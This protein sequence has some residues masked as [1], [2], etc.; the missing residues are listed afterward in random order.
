MALQQEGVVSD[1]THALLQQQ[2]KTNKKRTPLSC[3]RF[4]LL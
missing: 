3:V 2:Q 4:L 1:V